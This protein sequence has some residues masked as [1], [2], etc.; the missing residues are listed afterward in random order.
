MCCDVVVIGYVADGAVDFPT[1][2]HVQHRVAAMMLGV[3]HGVCC[4]E[5]RHSCFGCFKCVFDAANQVSKG[6]DCWC[7]SCVGCHD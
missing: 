7:C 5:V 4:V 6:E 2:F 3:V 1:T